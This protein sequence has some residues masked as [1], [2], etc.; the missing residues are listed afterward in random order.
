MYILEGLTKLRQ[1]CNSTALIPTEEDFG[2]Y[3]V[4]LEALMENIKEKTETIKF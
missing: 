1:I 4:K 2:N 3:S